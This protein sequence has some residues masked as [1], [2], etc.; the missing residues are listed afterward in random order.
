MGENGRTRAPKR[1]EIDVE[2]FRKI[3]DVQRQESN[4][5]YRGYENDWSRYVG[6]AKVHRHADALS[7]ITERLPAR[8]WLGVS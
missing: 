2:R 3:D 4:E 5:G 7:A 6:K 8:Y 1:H